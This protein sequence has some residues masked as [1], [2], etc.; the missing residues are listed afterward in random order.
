MAD[1]DGDSDE[2]RALRP[3]QA[4]ACIY[5]IGFGPRPGQKVLTVQHSMPR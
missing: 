3:L 2:T 1:N 4:A 5:R